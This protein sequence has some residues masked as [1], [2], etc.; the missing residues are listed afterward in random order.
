MA[1][2]SQVIDGHHLIGDVQ[3]EDI[4]D[5]AVTAAKLAD[6][7]ITSVKLSSRFVPYIGL[8]GYAE[9]GRCV[10]NFLT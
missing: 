9:Y 8:Y 3:T 2:V 6:G 1:K 10:Y 7:A 5:S 4:E